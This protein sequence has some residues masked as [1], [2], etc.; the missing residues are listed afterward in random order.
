MIVAQLRQHLGLIYPVQAFSC[1]HWK[2]SALQGL[3][4][5]LKVK[6]AIYGRKSYTKRDI[7]AQRHGP[8]KDA[9]PSN[10]V[11][12]AYYCAESALLYIAQ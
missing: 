10:S 11:A 6:T 4:D 2:R 8:T 5:A 7:C 12:S 9:V 1:L 3:I